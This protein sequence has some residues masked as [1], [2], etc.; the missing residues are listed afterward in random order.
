MNQI[1]DIL[2]H[3]NVIGRSVEKIRLKFEIEQLKVWVVMGGN[4][5]V[6]IMEDSEEAPSEV[7]YH[8][9]SYIFWSQFFFQSF[10]L[11]LNVTTSS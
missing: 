7:R 8:L 1:Y 11:L 6:L 10:S 9:S 4:Q 5:L 2:I 3:A